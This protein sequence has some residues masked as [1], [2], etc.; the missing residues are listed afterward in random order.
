V[1]TLVARAMAFA[2]K[3]H[4][5]HVDKVGKDYF[6]YHIAVVADRVKAKTTDPVA[7]ATAYLH[8]VVEDT[9]VGL[10]VI[11]KEFGDAV[12]DA[13]GMLTRPTGVPYAEYIAGLKAS[14]NETA[15]LV[16]LAD[17]AT[18]LSTPDSIPDTLVKRYKK[19]VAELNG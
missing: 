11:R 10:D 2:K 9:D 12:A 15:L 16:K 7:V 5:G 13:V 4:K 19:A 1:K 14:D 3:E 6:T 17:L 8:D 18:N